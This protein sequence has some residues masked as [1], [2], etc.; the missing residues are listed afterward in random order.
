MNIKK[1]EFIITKVA[2]KSVDTISP[3]QMIRTFNDEVRKL[4]RVFEFESGVRFDTLSESE[5]CL[6]ES[7]IFSC[8]NC[9]WTHLTEDVCYIDGEMYCQHCAEDFALSKIVGINDYDDGYS[10]YD[11]DPNEDSWE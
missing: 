7:L 2:L 9:G 4:E 11:Y 8:Q 5:I 10:P 1:R 6:V 3:E